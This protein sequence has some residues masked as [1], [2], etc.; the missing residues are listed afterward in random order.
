MKSTEGKLGRVFIIR[1]EDGDIIPGCIEKFAVEK[2]I[3]TGCVLLTGDVGEGR[4][5]V[6]PKTSRLKNPEPMVL[7]V[8]GVHEVVAAGILAPDASGSPVLH[9]HGALGRAGQTVTGCLREGVTTWLVAEVILIEILG[10]AAAR[11][12]DEES[13]FTL[14]KVLK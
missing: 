6:G 13:G 9:I 8:D 7:P 5:V 4:I 3:S 12:K 2:G 1:L 11:L 14:L 10:A